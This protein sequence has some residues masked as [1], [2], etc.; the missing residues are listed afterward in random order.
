MPSVL[1]V[2]WLRATRRRRWWVAFVLCAALSGLWAV[3]TP[4]FASP[5]EPAHAIRAAAVARGELKGTET[6]G[7][8]GVRDGAVFYR[9]PKVFSRADDV[10]CFAFKRD[11]SASCLYLGHPS[12]TARVATTAGNYP[13]AYYLLVGLPSRPFNSSISLYVMR[14]VSVLLAAALLASA[15]ATLDRFARPRLMALG[16]AVAVTPMVLFLGGTVNP[17]AVEIAAAI[18]AWISVVAIASEAGRGAVDSRLVVRA[19]VAL[20]ILSL[21]RT[22]S[23]LWVVAIVAAGLMLAGWSATRG[24]LRARAV[25]IGAGVVALS[26]L[27][28][29]AWTQYANPLAS[30]E[31]TSANGLSSYFIRRTVIGNGADLYRGM[32]GVFGWLDTPSPFGVTVLWTLVLGLVVVLGLAVAT[33]REVVVLSGLLVLTVIVPIVAGVVEAHSNGFFWQGRY[34]LPLAVGVP[35]VAAAAAARSSLGSTLPSRLP[36]IGV[37]L[38]ALCHVTDFAQALRRYTVGYDGGIMFWS[39]AQWSPP[40]GA[41]WLTLGF[42]VVV[43]AFAVW[44]VG[45]GADDRLQ[46]SPSAVLAEEPPTINLTG[47]TTTHR[48]STPEAQPLGPASASP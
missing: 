9:V 46:E 3:A 38:L 35:I 16:V 21:T 17:N 12:G 8:P 39:H 40:V 7:V 31:S 41:L 1:G 32:I 23:P 33:R 13:P 45:P 37:G 22:I 47:R 48:S 18:A 44:L 4:P 34:T 36:I 29:L 28:Q 19:T 14:L 26:V 24:L 15:I 11:T 27:A 25:Q 43:A 10:G 2:A 6:H 20:G 42:V 30:A 5:D